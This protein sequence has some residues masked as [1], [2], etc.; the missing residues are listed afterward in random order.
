MKIETQKL[1]G[2]PLD[3]AVAICLGAIDKKYPGGPLGFFRAAR[4]GGGL[5]YSSD[6]SLVERLVA[7]RKIK[8]YPSPVEGW[9]AVLTPDEDEPAYWFQTYGETDLIAGLRCVVLSTLGAEVDAPDALL[10]DAL[11]W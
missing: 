10:N 2:L 1:K 7:Y 5:R 3:W 8:I 11:G 4:A 9:K 6:E